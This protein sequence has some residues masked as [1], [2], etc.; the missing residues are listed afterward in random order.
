MSVLAEVPKKPN[1]M[2]DV[3]FRESRKQAGVFLQEGVEEATRI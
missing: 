3:I 1:K 2:S